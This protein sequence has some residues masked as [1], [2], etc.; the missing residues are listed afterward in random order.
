MAGPIN[1][2]SA[3]YGFINHLEG[4][5]K[6]LVVAGGASVICFALLKFC[7]PLPDFFVD[8]LNYIIWTRSRT[9]V[10]YR[11]IGYS[12]FLKFLHNNISESITAVVVV[13]YLLFL[14]SS[15]FCFFSFDYLYGI[16]QKLRW[17]AFLLIVFNP[18]L[19]IQT[20]L[21]SSDSL[22]CSLT[23]CWLTACL[24]IIKQHRWWALVVQ[25]VFL[26]C[27]F[28]VRYTA[29][30]FPLVAVIAFVA[31]GARIGY[32]ILGIVFTVLVIYVAIN[33]QADAV[34]KVT[35]TRVF[36]GF[37]GWQLANN[38][39]YY[40]KKIKV[41]TNTLPNT[42]TVVVDR[43]V[44][45]YIDSVQKNDSI[46]SVYIWDKVSPLKMYVYY[47][48]SRDHM[49]YFP[50][51][52]AAS[53]TYS[54]YASSIIKGNPMAFLNYFILPNTKNFFYPEPEMLYNY[55]CSNTVLDSFAQNWYHF[56][57]KTLS[58]RYPVLQ[59]NIVRVYPFFSLLLNV[60]NIGVIFMFLI[61][62]APV[63][64]RTPDYI[65]GLYI[66]WAVFYFAYFGFSVFATVVTLR[67]MDPIYVMGF[68]VP[69]VLLGYNRAKLKALAAMARPVVAMPQQPVKAKKSVPAK[70][71]K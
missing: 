52:V 40:Y 51:W 58:C 57:S 67:Y 3:K 6:M 20:N 65:K 70:R 24:W 11:P 15:L 47:R 63:W 26:Y 38:V 45:H 32:K 1:I 43:F 55:N 25:I 69:A 5:K 9:V 12:L 30:F 64:R 22:F 16:P 18:I 2:D 46:G 37:S 53:V 35:G 33:K 7:F 8:S 48:S 28:Q 42:E 56:D 34:E 60:F 62:L 21:I 4:Q 13:H 71:K 59:K 10:E 19:I 50:E 29:L 27:S 49:K 17:P 41:D 36:S 23:V 31:S 68:I 61:W 54:D 66:T 39:L 44:R 14:L